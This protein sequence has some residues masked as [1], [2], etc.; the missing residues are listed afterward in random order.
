M[1]LYRSQEDILNWG[2]KFSEGFIL[3][4][5]T[6][7]MAL[8]LTDPEIVK[9]VLP[10]PLQPTPMPMGMAYVAEFHETNFGVAYNEAALFLDAQYEGIP[11]RYCL[12]MPV[13]NDIALIGGREVYGFP[14]KIA[15]TIAVKKEGNKVT[16]TC[17]R[18]GFSIIQI[19][20]KLTG[21]FG[22]PMPPP[23]PNY[24]YKC[25]FSPTLK[26]FDYNPRLLKQYNDV[27]WGEIEIGEGTV[28]LGK[29]PY[30]FLGDIPIQQILMVGYAQG[31]EIHMN[32]GEVI[33]EVSTDAYLP[34]VFNKQDSVI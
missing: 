29:S 32:P 12:S 9:S 15:E 22:G 17:V 10:P 7:V 18:R 28:A 24:L 6:M 1:K 23:V 21:P 33:A 26:G 2:K 25:F 34:Y 3:G 5:A 14:K 4:D 13:T 31:M 20:A 11:G 16:G 30:D 19:E 8:F 27:T